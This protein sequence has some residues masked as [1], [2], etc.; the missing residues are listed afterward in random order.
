MKGPKNVDKADVAVLSKGGR[1]ELVG[2]SARRFA[3][4]F[5]VG[6]R[7]KFKGVKRR[8][9][10]VAL[11]RKG[12]IRAAGA[13]AKSLK[14]KAVARDIRR[15]AAARASQLA[16]P[17]FTPADAQRAGRLTGYTLAGA[18]NPELNRALTLYC[19]LQLG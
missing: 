5:R 8:G 9:R 15:V 19:Q 13:A 16:K 10:F 6:N 14:R 18:S 12:R 1:V 4:P 7:A 3:G 2:T 17:A 11:A